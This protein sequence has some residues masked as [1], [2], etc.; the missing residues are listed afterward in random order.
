MVNRDAWS[1]ASELINTV[2]AVAELGG[3]LLKVTA[4]NILDELEPDALAGMGVP[5]L[6]AGGPS[7]AHFAESLLQAARAGFGGICVGRNLFQ[8]SHGIAS[9]LVDIDAAFAQQDA[10]R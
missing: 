2:R 5:V 9:A 3:D 6:F 4:G 7:G 1:T 10:D 8:A